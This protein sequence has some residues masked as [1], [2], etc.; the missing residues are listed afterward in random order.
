MARLEDVGK[1]LKSAFTM[2]ST[3]EPH[4]MAGRAARIRA[5]EATADL[6]AL[7]GEL[8]EGVAPVV[9]AAAERLRR[10]G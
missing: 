4:T 5:E 10:R 8:D 7:V 9:A 6:G 3:Y 2:G 1:R